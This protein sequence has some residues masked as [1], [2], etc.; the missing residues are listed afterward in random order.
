MKNI[1]TPFSEVSKKTGS[2]LVVFWF[3]FFLF[4]FQI[5][6]SPIIP[7]SSEILGAFI[8]LVSSEAFYRDLLSSLGFT[9][10][11]M[12]ISL[13]ITGTIVYLSTIPLFKPLAQFVSKC[14]Y[15]TLSGLIYLFIAATRNVSDAKFVLL[16]FGIVPYFVTSFL[17]TVISIPQEQI[18]KSIVNRNNKWE[19]LLEVVI[20][21]KADQL[22]EIAR[23]NFAISW[24]MI[25]MVEGLAQNEGGLG[26]LII[27][28][29]KTMVLPVVFATLI[30]ILL[31]GIFFDWFLSYLRNLLFTYTK[32]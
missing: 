7:K 19:T 14:R 2:T 15:L 17:S 11:A 25:T 26:V 1:I 32:L 6:R 31:L 23:Q 9:F 16:V 18:D 22:M 4:L 28:N 21:G 30:V 27:R 13:L 10:K 20:I 29:G 12:G 24:L 8:N 3:I 5:L